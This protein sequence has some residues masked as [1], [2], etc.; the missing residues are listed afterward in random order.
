MD[1]ASWMLIA[2]FDP[3]RKEM[4]HALF[5]LADE[6]YDVWIGSNRFTRYSNVNTDFPDADNPSSPNYAT[7]NKAKYDSSW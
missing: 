4:D 1:A 2:Q 3:S 6:G 5:N 7:Q